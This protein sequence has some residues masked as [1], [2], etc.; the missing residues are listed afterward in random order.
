MKFK[1]D[2]EVRAGLKDG[3]NDIGTQGQLLSSTGTV[4]TG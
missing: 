3:D 2:I 1:S 4:T